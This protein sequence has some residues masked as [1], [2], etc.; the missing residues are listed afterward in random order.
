MIL[1][2][3]IFRFLRLL[4]FIVSGNEIYVRDLRTVLFQEPAGG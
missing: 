4:L 2:F 1:V 3:P